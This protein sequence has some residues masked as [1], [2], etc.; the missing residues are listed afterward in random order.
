MRERARTDL[1]G[2]RS[3]MVVPT[4]TLTLE[5]EF[6]LTF[7]DPV[8]QPLSD[9]VDQHYTVVRLSVRGAASHNRPRNIG[10]L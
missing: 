9:E 3:A 2:G 5:T 6:W 4:A 8:S 10:N 1:C 7:R